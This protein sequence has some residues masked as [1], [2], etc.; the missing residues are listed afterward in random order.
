MVWRRL[1]LTV[2]SSLAFYTDNGLF[3]TV[4]AYRRP[5]EKKQLS[6]INQLLRLI[7]K[8]HWLFL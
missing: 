5:K 1:Q 6:I 8:F 4:T 2:Y 3:L 7:I